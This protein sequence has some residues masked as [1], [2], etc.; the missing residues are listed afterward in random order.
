MQDWRAARCRR[1]R[2]LKA[3]PG[4][5]QAFEISGDGYSVH[6]ATLDED[7]SAQGIAAGIPSVEYRVLAHV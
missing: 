7:L 2:L 1:R 4:D 3:S 6:W 5:R